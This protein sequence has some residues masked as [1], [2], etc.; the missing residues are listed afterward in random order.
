MSTPTGGFF[1]IQ[2]NTAHISVASGK[3]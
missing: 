2:G 1:E 3:L